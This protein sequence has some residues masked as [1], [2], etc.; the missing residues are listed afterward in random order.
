[1][2]FDL[3]ERLP[4]D[5]KSCKDRDVKFVCLIISLF[6]DEGAKFAATDVAAATNNKTCGS[7][8]EGIS[9]FAPWAFTLTPGGLYSVSNLF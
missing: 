1:M 2:G 3:E 4:A 8:H 5:L 6:D 7:H 9:A